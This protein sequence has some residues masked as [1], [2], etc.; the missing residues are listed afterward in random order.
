MNRLIFIFLTIGLFQSLNVYAQSSSSEETNGEFRNKQSHPIFLLYG[1]DI[2]ETKTGEVTKVDSISFSPYK[3]I[4]FNFRERSQEQPWPYG[5]GFLIV[6]ESKLGHE[7][8]WHNLIYGDFG[9]HTFSWIDF[10]NDGDKDL[11]YL[12]GFEDVFESRLFLNQINTINK[13][14]FK[15]VYNND[16]AYCAIVDFNKDGVPEI[17]N[18]IQ[19][20]DSEDYVLAEAWEYELEEKERIEISKE[21]DRIIGRFD[22]CNFDYNMPKNYKDFS[23]SI[24]SDV[25]ILA[26]VN[27][28]VA[29]V[30]H[31][32]PE[33]FC[34]RK[35]I[36]QNIN[37]AGEKIKPWLSELEIKYSDICN[38]IE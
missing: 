6:N 14:A 35:S 12:I 28:T 16:I 2:L 29:D 11:Y 32:Y 34:F 36:L 31:N 21:Y 8:L 10:D 9:P 25:N 37:N 15:E 4:H 13:L 27:D 33:H 24:S 17:L 18:Q 1:L 22:Q 20:I 3:V 26:I 23:I 5:A 38:R 7:V 30:S 19:N